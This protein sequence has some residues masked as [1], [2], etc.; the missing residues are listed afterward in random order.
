MGCLVI[1]GKRFAQIREAVLRER[2]SGF[3]S[4]EENRPVLTII[5]V[6]SEVS[7]N[8]YVNRK[9]EACKRVGIFTRYLKL[10]AKT[11]VE[12]L[13]RV[14]IDN[15]TDAL[16][17]AIIVQLPLPSHVDAWE[18]LSLIEPCKDVDCLTPTNQG[19]LYMSR[20]YMY[21]CTPLACIRLIDLT[22]W[23][24]NRG[25]PVFEPPKVSLQGKKVAIFGR[26]NL[27]GKPL[28]PLLLERDATVTV[29]HSKTGNWR[30]V[31]EWADISILATGNLE[32]FPASVFK[33]NSIVIDVGISRKPD[34]TI[35][36]DLLVD[37]DNN[38]A[39]YTPVPG[40]VGPMTVQCLLENVYLAFQNGEKSP[41]NLIS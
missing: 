16:T 28:I 27:V 4:G 11:P 19:K 39:A 34:G 25:E 8:V 31:A 41:V 37:S 35:G 5:Q 17:D 24:L 6:G 1:P 14:V 33:P 32:F 29:C 15:N 38:L 12:E 22:F 26:S 20:S 9:L 3:K 13:K 2:L 10:D 7:S 21:P 23:M 18:I 30:E 40:G 36:G